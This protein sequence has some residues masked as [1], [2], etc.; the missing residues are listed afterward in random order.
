MRFAELE[1]LVAR[2]FEVRAL[3]LGVA[4]QF[5]DVRAPRGELGELVGFGLLERGDCLLRDRQDVLQPDRFRLEGRGLLL[6]CA[7]I[8]AQ[9]VVGDAR[10][11]QDALEAELLALAFLVGAQRLG[12][13]IDQLADRALDDLEFADLV[14]GVQQEIADDLVLLAKLRRDRE[15]QLVVEFDVALVRRGSGLGLRRHRRRRGL[16]LRLGRGLEGRCAGW[17]LGRGRGF[18]AEKVDKLGH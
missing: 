18:A 10:V 9:L 12:D 1:V 6:R 7:E 16:A 4:L 3:L 13:R 5:G 15:E 14:L 17:F 11:V 2:R 8:V